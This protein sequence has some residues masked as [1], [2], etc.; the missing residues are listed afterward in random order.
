MERL[1]P[2]GRRGSNPLRIP[3]MTKP[4]PARRCSMVK[5]PLGRGGIWAKMAA[6]SGSRA[7]KVIVSEIGVG[8]KE[9]GS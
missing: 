2:F 7:L 6:I 5:G 3:S 8:I 9:E 4:K 1:L